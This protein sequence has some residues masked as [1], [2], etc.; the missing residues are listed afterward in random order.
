VAS[1]FSN[2]AAVIARSHGRRVSIAL[3][4]IASAHPKCIEG[5]ALR[6]AGATTVAIAGTSGD[7]R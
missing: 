6:G 3:S 5:I 7:S 1:T 2:H 4:H